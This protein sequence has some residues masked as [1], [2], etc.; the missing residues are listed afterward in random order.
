MPELSKRLLP[1]CAAALLAACAA[2]VKPTATAAPAAVP[3]GPVDAARL[4]AADREPGS[5]LSTGRNYSEQRYSPLAAV[6]KSNVAQLGLAWS[7]KLDVDRA[8]EATPIVVDGVMLV[9]SAFSIVTALDPRDGHELWKFDPKV[10]RDLDRDGCCDAANRGVAVWQ[11][12]VYVGA[13]DGRLIALDLKTGAKLWETDTI[14]DHKRS[15][16]ISGAPRVVKGKVIIGNGGAE[17][18]VR[19]YIGA[20]DAETGALAWRFYTV[21]GD[22]SRPAEN[23]AME[24]ARKTWFGDQYY[25]LGGGGT[26]WDSMAYDPELDLLYIGTGNGSS[27]NRKVRSEGKGD[28]LFLSSIVALRPDSGEYVWHYQTTPGETWDFTATQSI[29]LADLKI[30]GQTRKVLMQAPKNGFFYVVDRVTGKLISAE[31]FVTV[32]WASKVDLASGRPV[33][34][35]DG[36]WTSQPKL[37]FPG[38]LGAH[39]W[40]PMSYSPQTGLVYI[41]AQQAPYLYVPDN[42]QRYSGRGRWHTG[43]A[44]LAVPENNKELQGIAG[45]YKGQLLA[46]DPVAQKV[47]WSQDYAAIW[48]GGTLATAGNLVFQGTADGRFV[49]YAAD[50]GDKL[51]ETPA[52]T[53]VMAGPMSYEIDGVQYVSVAAGWGGA[54]PLAAGALAA[55]GTRADARILTYKLGG[56][57]SLP[58]PKTA[59]ALPP[60]PPLTAKP[61]VVAKGRDL[62]NEHCG[63]CHGASAIGGGVLPDLRKLTPEKHQIFA[64]IVAGA[65]I[66]KGMPSLMDVL[67]PEDVE[68]IHQYLIAR[69]QDLHREA[70]AG[71]P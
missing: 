39:N 59:V 70:A 26:V 24:M 47:A 7:Y 4:I 60:P 36:D 34:S 12:K 55:P 65:Y 17:L 35:P 61:A 1:L 21:P 71:S 66:D 54:L 2:E 11:N 10:R 42:A 28:N 27:W 32:N 49:A 63:V 46:W 52:N 64:G 5:W 62:Y 68:A 15:Y 22:P 23:A 67:K 8:T 37:V 18:G 38:P 3:S 16:T 19:G 31:K 43:S 20:Y 56:T 9:T 48:N 51:W 33:E 44:P 53:G 25:K 13:Y 29:I 57:A 30:E 58:A 50:K 6:N 14:V 69:A 45:L 40:Q 41:P